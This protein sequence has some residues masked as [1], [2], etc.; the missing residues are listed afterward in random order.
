MTN[1]LLQEKTYFR[2]KI[3]FVSGYPLFINSAEKEESEQ[4][5]EKSHLIVKA[6][7]YF[8]YLKILNMKMI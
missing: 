6:V 3:L 1:K 2:Q 8:T 4:S 5:T 7:L